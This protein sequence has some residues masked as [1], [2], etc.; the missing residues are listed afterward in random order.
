LFFV[1]LFFFLSQNF[2]LILESKFQLYH[3]HLIKSTKFIRFLFLCFDLDQ[4]LLQMKSSVITGIFQ[5]VFC[6]K[7]N[8][9]SIFWEFIFGMIE[10]MI[11]STSELNAMEFVV[12]QMQMEIQDK[13]LQSTFQ[14]THIT[15]D[16]NTLDY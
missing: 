9:D 8:L 1:F 6:K 13:P 3:F 10:Y 16:M 7:R 11:V 2:K 14:I 4:P 12:M 15:V 5:T